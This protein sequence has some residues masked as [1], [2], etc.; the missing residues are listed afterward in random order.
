M[1]QEQSCLT[2]S[3]EQ[4]Q[5]WQ[6]PHQ[7][8]CSPTVNEQNRAKVLI[9]DATGSPR[10]G[11]TMNKVQ[12]QSKRQAGHK[13]REKTTIYVRDPSTVHGHRQDW[14]QTPT[15][16]VRSPASQG[17]TRPG[18]GCLQDSSGQYRRILRRAPGATCR[19]CAGQG[20]R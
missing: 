13:A 14:N 5:H 20:L 18:K 9:T 7:P 3:Q 10:K 11:M 16:L 19:G 15:G 4:P 12:G 1:L 6:C 2:R 8:W 17:W